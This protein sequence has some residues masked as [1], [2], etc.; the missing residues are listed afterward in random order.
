M[1]KTKDARCPE[2][3]AHSTEGFMRRRDFICF[4]TGAALARPRAAIAD[5]PSKV[6]RLA[7][8]TPGAPLNEETPLGATLLK[9]LEQHNYTLGKNL[10]F[11]ARGAA[12]HV[13]KLGEIVRRLKAGGVDVIVAVGFPAILAS[14]GENVPTVV[15]YGGVDPVATRLIDAL[16]RPGGN[17]TGISDNATTLS[18][19]RLALIK[20]AVPKIQRVAMLW[21]RNDLGMSMRYDAAGAARSIGVS[22]QALGVRESDDFNGVFEAM[23]RERPEAILLVADVLTALHRKRVFDYAAEHKIPALYEYDDPWVRDGGLMSYG[24]DLKECIGR[25]AHLVARIFNGARPADLPFEEPRRYLLVINL[26]TAK[27]TG[28]DL[29]S[30]F[31]ALADEVIE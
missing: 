6:F 13:S 10:S 27:A 5:T 8:L 31:L 23:D 28:I 3:A 30:N 29:P 19:K 9:G 26:K 14:K 7:T 15:A 2:A 11:E 22:V 25:A 18:T 16:A 12:G 4:L 17:I 24:P 20:Q 21:N 1:P